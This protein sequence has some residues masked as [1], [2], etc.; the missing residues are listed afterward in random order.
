MTN[1]EVKPGP[2]RSPGETA[3]IVLALAKQGKGIREIARLCDISTQAA[4]GHLKRLRTAGR[5]DGDAA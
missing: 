2:R 4:G 5:L 1:H 3:E